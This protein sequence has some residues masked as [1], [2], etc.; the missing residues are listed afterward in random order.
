MSSWL[1]LHLLLRVRKTQ[2]KKLSR[3]IKL[4]VHL[5]L[6]NPQFENKCK[7]MDSTTARI[8]KKMH[9]IESRR[10]SAKH[11]YNKDPPIAITNP[12]VGSIVSK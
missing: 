8:G 6:H 1:R 11:C 12:H 7:A 4:Q 9:C 10:K 5:E 2:H 3:T